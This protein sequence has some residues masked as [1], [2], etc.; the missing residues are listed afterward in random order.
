MFNAK[1]IH[2]KYGLSDKNIDRIQQIFPLFPEVEAVILFGSRARGHFH[3]GSDVDLALKGESI[4]LETL[5]RI[6]RMLDDLMLPIQFDILIY[7]HVS[8]P[9][10]LSQ[11]EEEGVS[12][13]QKASQPVS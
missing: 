12:I 6:S 5:L 8:N 11:I 4:Q 2:M 1:L 7:H 9:D 3:P 10:L 13:Y